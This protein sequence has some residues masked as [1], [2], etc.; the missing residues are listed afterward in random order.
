MLH[1]EVS[2]SFHAAQKLCKLRDGKGDRELRINLGVVFAVLSQCATSDALKSH[3]ESAQ[4]RQDS[5]S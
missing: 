2:V 4:K 1:S 5:N 3:K